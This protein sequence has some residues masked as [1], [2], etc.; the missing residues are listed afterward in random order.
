MIRARLVWRASPFTKE[1]VVQGSSFVKGLARQTKSAPSLTMFEEC[2]NQQ[3]YTGPGGWSLVLSRSF[4]TVGAQGRRLPMN[5]WTLPEGASQSKVLSRYNAWGYRAL[6]GI[7]HSVQ[8]AQDTLVSSVGATYVLSH[9]TEKFVS[10]RRVVEVDKGISN[11]SFFF[12]TNTSRHLTSGGKAEGP[13]PLA[14]F[15]VNSE[16]SNISARSVLLDVG[17]I[18]SGLLIS[19]PPQVL[20]TLESVHHPH[21]IT[22]FDTLGPS[23]GT[24]VAFSQSPSTGPSSPCSSG[25]DCYHFL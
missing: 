20:L 15:N 13:P 21:Y 18:S 6:D 2:Q 25:C 23:S 8:Q 14:H 19:P 4:V 11:A 3:Y 1:E 22:T 5:D 17:K 10:D 12:P 9:D 7:A 24:A 16:S